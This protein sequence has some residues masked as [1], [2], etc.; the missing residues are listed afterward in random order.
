MLFEWRVSLIED[1]NHFYAPRE[2]QLLDL[3]PFQVKPE[4]QT[5]II[6]SSGLF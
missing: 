2:V 6:N 5:F 4:I 3:Q 1:P